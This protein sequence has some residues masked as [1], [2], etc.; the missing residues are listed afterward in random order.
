MNPRARLLV[1][2]FVLSAVLGLGCGSGS[3]CLGVGWLS[4]GATQGMSRSGMNLQAAAPPKQVGASYL[5]A[6]ALFLAS[7]GPQLLAAWA[8]YRGKAWA[9]TA[10]LVGALGTLAT[11]MPLSPYVFFACLRLRPDAAPEA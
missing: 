8:L 5:V 3:C 10:G 7:A 9:R 4:G 1:L 2:A 11:C 6:A